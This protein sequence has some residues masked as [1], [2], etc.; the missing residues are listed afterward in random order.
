MGKKRANQTGYEKKIGKGGRSYWA[1]IDTSNST[2]SKQSLKGNFESK[3]P[4]CC[5]QRHPNWKT[6]R[7]PEGKTIHTNCR[8]SFEHSKES[9]SKAIRENGIVRWSSN[10][11][12]PMPDSLEVAFKAGWI[13]EEE[14]ET[15]LENRKIEVEK[16]L[17]EYREN[18]PTY[19]AED[20]AEKKML[21]EMNLFIIL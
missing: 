20:I 13:S 11:V 14:F 16:S 10:N 12:I 1:K 6:T 21:L 3:E 8:S 2:L 5:S 18:P 15:S 17:R 19:S 4:I 9:Y 7:T